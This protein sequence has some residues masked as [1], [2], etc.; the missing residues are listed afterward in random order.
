MDREKPA[1]IAKI[2]TRKNSVPHGI[3]RKLIYKL[4]H[5]K[6]GHCIF[7][8]LGWGSQ[9][10]IFLKESTKANLEFSEGCTGGSNRKPSMGEGVWIFSRATQEPQFYNQIKCAHFL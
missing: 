3:S 6:Q 4:T 7:R 5:R 8:G 10:V 9:K 1:K 2:R